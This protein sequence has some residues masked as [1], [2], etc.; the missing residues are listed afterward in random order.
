MVKF[1][2]RW[3]QYSSYDN[4]TNLSLLLQKVMENTSS[5]QH[6]IY[7]HK[8]K[9]YCFDKWWKHNIT[10][11]VLTC[12]SKYD[13]KHD[14]TSLLLTK[15]WKTHHHFYTLKCNKWSTKGRPWNDNISKNHF[16]NI[17]VNGSPPW[18][19][20]SCR[21]I[22]LPGSRTDALSLRHYSGWSLQQV[23]LWWPCLS[24]WLQ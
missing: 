12:N 11:R 13:S 6:M 21:T 9:H 10:F 16:S 1:T 4:K 14:Q 5:L 23:A 20:F 7:I 15:W 19:G 3:T 18:G 17:N 2:T 22:V 8:A 24:Q